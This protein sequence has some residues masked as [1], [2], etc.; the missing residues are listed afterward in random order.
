M[1]EK[2]LAVAAQVLD[3]LIEYGIP[4]FTALIRA[5]KA[6]FGGD[7]TEEQMAKLVME[8]T[9]DAKV[10]AALAKADAAGNG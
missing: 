4:A 5:I 2:Q 10:R 1:S 7:L 6:V 9:Q 3:L 8:F